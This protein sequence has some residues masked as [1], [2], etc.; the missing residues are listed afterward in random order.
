[1]TFSKG[2]SLF[3]GIVYFSCNHDRNKLTLGLY[4]SVALPNNEK[5]RYVPSF[6]ISPSSQPPPTEEPTPEAGNGDAPLFYFKEIV[7]EP[8][9][10]VS[11]TIQDPP[12]PAAPEPVS[13][14]QPYPPPAPVAPAQPYPPPAPVVPAQP[15][16]PP[17]PDAPVPA[18]PSPVYYKPFPPEESPAPPAEPA[19]EPNPPAEE[20]GPTESELTPS[21]VYYKYSE[22]SSNPDNVAPVAEAQEP[23]QEEGEELAGFPSQNFVNQENFQ[24]PEFFR[25]FLNTPPKWINMNNW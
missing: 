25:T 10:E 17:V 12:A 15:Y 24:I 9:N 6:F 1:M 21:P 19:L 4:N 5:E 18:T 2:S 14:A 7:E 16:P 11:D 23:K 3:I 20:Q 13:P 8:D 22:D